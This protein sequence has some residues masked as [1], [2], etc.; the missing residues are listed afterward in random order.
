MGVRV[1]R[2]KVECLAD[3][4]TA[5][6]EIVKGIGGDANRKYMVDFITADIE[7]TNIHSLEIALPYHWQIFAGGVYYYGR[8]WK[9]FIHIL[10]NIRCKKTLVCYIHNL[11]Y[12]FKFLK[13]WVPFQSVKVVAMDSRT[14]LRATVYGIEFRCSYMLTNESLDKL[15]KT[16]DVQH[17]KMKDDLDYR[18]YRT[19]FTALTA[20]EEG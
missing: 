13:S 19:P 9:D 2:K 4:D 16:W 14:I 11:G 18:V 17:K 1:E 20:R 10:K 3:A 15:C 12:E 5:V 8:F 6:K 7:C